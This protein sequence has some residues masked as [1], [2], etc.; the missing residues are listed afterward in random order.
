MTSSANRLSL[1]RMMRLGVAN[2]SACLNLARS[3]E[4]ASRRPLARA[5]RGEEKSEVLAAHSFPGQGIEALVDGRRV[6]IGTEAF[7]AELCR[8]PPAGP[9]HPN[10]DAYF[11]FLAEDGAWL[12]AFELEDKQRPEAGAAPARALWM[13]NCTAA[14]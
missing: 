3:L 11:V 14:T 10:F 8:L 13:E 6:R 1:A 2:E 5:F 9:A 7:C 4:A 12:A